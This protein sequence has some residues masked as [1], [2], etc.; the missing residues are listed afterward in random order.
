MPSMKEYGRIGQRRYAGMFSEEFLRELQ[1]RRGIEVYREMAE[2][3]E[4][5]G[6]IIYAI[7][8]LIRQAS[9][10]VQPGGSTTKD[11]ECAEFIES[12]MNDMQDTWTD[13]ILSLIHI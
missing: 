10:S 4:I 8:T 12:C 11:S 9:W 5:C 7:E 2:N 1:G 3:D 6:A 13:T